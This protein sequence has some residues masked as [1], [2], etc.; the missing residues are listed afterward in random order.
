MRGMDQFQIPQEKTKTPAEQTAEMQSKV[1]AKKGS[2]KSTIITMIFC[3]IASFVL[4]LYVMEVD[5]PVWESEFSTVKV[6]V[7]TTAADGTDNGLSAMTAGTSQVVDVVLRGRKTVL[8]ALKAEDIDAYVDASSVTTAGRNTYPVKIDAPEGTSVVSC[9]PSELTVYLDKK[10]TKEVPVTVKLSEY[11][12]ASEYIIGEKTPS[13]ETILVTGP[14]TEL[15]QVD[16]AQLVLSPPSGAITGSFSGTG[17]PQL[18]DKDGTVVSSRYL[19]LNVEE[20]SA[21]VNVYIKKTLKLTATFKYGYLD[22]KTAN[23]TFEPS[24]IEVRGDVQQLSTMEEFSVGE[25]DETKIVVSRE[26]SESVIQFVPEF[27]SG[28]TPTEPLESVTAKVRLLNAYDKIVL[29]NQFS[30]QNAPSGKRVRVV[31]SELK[32]QLR[33]ALSKLNVTTASDINV[34]VDLKNIDPDS[35]AEQV[36]PAQVTLKDGSSSEMYVWGEYTVS[37]RVG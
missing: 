4:W 32:V 22:A 18:I 6:T 31:T 35:T 14:E 10:T 19:T 2:R 23:V 13:V 27:P 17:R 30:L 16:Q 15:A 33:G 37:V 20:I 3:V 1:P 25:I 29:T 8:T 11:T 34:V 28:I 36:V 7:R 12:I 5:S 21:L 26:T 24:Q 9:S